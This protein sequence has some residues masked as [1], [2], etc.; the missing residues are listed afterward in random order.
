MSGRPIRI[1]LGASALSRRAL[2]GSA[3]GTW[4]TSAKRR[5]SRWKSCKMK[6]TVSH[7]VVAGGLFAGGLEDLAASLGRHLAHEAVDADPVDRLVPGAVFVGRDQGNARQLAVAHG[8]CPF[9]IRRRRRSRWRPR[10]RCWC[11][12]PASGTWNL[13]IG[14]GRALRPP[15]R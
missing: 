3:G 14:S 11:L 5:L 8:R 1:G 6:R 7:D 9:F 4:T 12:R 15:L 13:R 2:P 10:R